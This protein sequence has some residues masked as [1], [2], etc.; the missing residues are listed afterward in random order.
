VDFGDASSEIRSYVV[1]VVP[2]RP[3]SNRVS[4]QDVRVL[5]AMAIVM[6]RM[7]EECKIA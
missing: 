7:L 1:T 3:R 5:D 6:K 2:I 4:K